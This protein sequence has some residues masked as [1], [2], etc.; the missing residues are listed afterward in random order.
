MIVNWRFL[1]SFSYEQLTKLHP[2]VDEY[3]L[4]YAQVG[5]KAIENTT[6]WCSWFN[7]FLKKNIAAS[8]HL[9]FGLIFQSL[10]KAFETQ[11]AMKI[12]H[13]I[14]NPSMQSKVTKQ[15]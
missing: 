15:L 14:E 5:V 1:C 9:S 10:H 4:Y 3:K 13:Q 6:Y 2:E 11:E 8:I 12:T 7:N